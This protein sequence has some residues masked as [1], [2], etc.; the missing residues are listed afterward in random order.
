M[1]ILTGIAFYISYCN[2]AVHSDPFI[3]RLSRHYTEKDGR[4]DLSWLSVARYAELNSLV[5]LVLQPLSAQ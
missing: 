3:Q 1:W 5:N 4:K 2:E